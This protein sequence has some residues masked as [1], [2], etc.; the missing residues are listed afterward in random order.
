M[1]TLKDILDKKKTLLSAVHTAAS[2]DQNELKVLAT[3]LFK[4]EETQVLSEKT[5]REYGE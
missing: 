3:V 1:E 2:S 4:F 5:T